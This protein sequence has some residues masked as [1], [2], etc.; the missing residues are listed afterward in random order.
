MSTPPT[1][2]ATPALFNQR[3][4]AEYLRCSASTLFRLE[5]AGKLRPVRLS[6]RKLLYPQEMLDSILADWRF[7][8]G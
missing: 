1:T 8:K 4:A 5:K 3:E 2:I 6:S 7:R